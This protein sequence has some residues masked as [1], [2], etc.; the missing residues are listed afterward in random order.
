MMDWMLLAKWGVIPVAMGA[1]FLVKLYWPNYQD[2]NI[3]EETIEQVIESQTGIDVDL[4][5]LSSEKNNGTKQ[6]NK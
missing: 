1:V 4:T 5:P 2:D 6:Q 3:V